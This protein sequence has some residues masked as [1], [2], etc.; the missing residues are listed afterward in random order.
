MAISAEHLIGLVDR[1]G[2]NNAKREFYLTDIVAIARG[3]GLAVTV[4]ELPAEEVLGVN[5]RAELAAAEAL[6]QG[7]CGGARWRRAP[8]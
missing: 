5:T 8:P 4:A 1:I 6:M 2:D 7:G 3:R